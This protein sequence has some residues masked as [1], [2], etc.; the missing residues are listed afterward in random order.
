MWVEEKPRTLWFSL[1]I[2]ISSFKTNRHILCCAVLYRCIPL[3]PRRE[4]IWKEGMRWAGDVSDTESEK[5]LTRHVVML[6]TMEPL[7]G[8]PHGEGDTL[9]CEIIKI[10]LQY[11]YLSVWGSLK[12]CSIL[13]PKGTSKW[14]C[15]WELGNGC[16]AKAFAVKS[17]SV[18]VWFP[19]THIKLGHIVPMG[20]WE[21]E[22]SES[23]ETH[24]PVVLLYSAA[25]NRDLVSSK[26]KS[27]NWH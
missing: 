3:W 27:D 15:Y 12:K 26:V 17:M 7:W 9:L 5:V 18:W 4:S 2:P 16:V 22:T 10:S 20:K 25:K 21:P 6:E 8:C 19:R 11:R 24:G 23:P 1:P 14:M 13:I